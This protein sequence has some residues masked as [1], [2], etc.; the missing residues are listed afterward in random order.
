MCLYWKKDGSDLAVV[1]IYVD[2][3]LAKGTNAEAVE[4]FFASLGGLFIENL[5][6]VCEVLG[7]RVNVDNDGG[8]VVTQKGANSN[9]L[10]EHTLEGV[11]SILN[12]IGSDCYKVPSVDSALLIAADGDAP[13]ILSF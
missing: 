2:Y 12:S 10:K 9:L 6:T 3:L 13:G 4:L 7:L 5:G 1:G 8:N 11:N